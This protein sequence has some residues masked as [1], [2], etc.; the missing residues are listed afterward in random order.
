MMGEL[1]G[2]LTEP[3]VA[4]ATLIEA[5]ELGLLA[6]LSN[7]AGMLDADIGDLTSHIVRT[8]LARADD[9]AWVQLIGVMNRSA[10][11]GLA[12]LVLMVEQ[13]LAEL[14]TTTAH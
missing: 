12:A 10:V 1:V 13:A 8:W 14:D 3:G 6:R 7:A 9:E 11:P 4:E 5:G 2:R